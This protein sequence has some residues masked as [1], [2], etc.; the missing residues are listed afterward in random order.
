MKK[1]FTLMASA[2][3]CTITYAQ[4]DSS[5]TKKESDTI[6]IGNIIIVKNGGRSESGNYRN[7]DIHRRERR[8][9]SNVSTNWGI[10]DIGFANYR[11][12]TNYA[13]T[14]GYLY[15]RQGAAPLGKSDF[16]LKTGKSINI[17]I[18]FFMQRLNVI[19]HHVNLKYGL[20]I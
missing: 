10:V 4:A 8:E 6:R 9:S 15:D 5:T 20:G 11:D 16:S 18:W 12:L 1:L 2:M 19:K 14:G 7:F 3:F 13:N 17:N